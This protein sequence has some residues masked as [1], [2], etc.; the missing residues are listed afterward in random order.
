MRREPAPELA[1]V[2]GACGMAEVSVD[3][4]PDGL[5]LVLWLAGA[6]ARRLMPT[7]FW[8]RMAG[9]DMFFAHRGQLFNRAMFV[10]ER[11]VLVDD[12]EP[13]L[14]DAWLL[15]ASPSRPPASVARVTVDLLT[16]GRVAVAASARGQ[17]DCRF[18]PTTV[19]NAL[20][21]DLPKVLAE[22]A[23]QW[24]SPKPDRK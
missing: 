5:R 17:L 23:E 3:F 15:G 1:Q 7:G 13:R 2:A 18:V 20:S 6:E 9:A 14:P 8:L 12:P 4:S 19:E 21:R 11:A 22:L 24:L 10:A 16:D